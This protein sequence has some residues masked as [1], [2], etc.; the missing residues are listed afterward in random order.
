MHIIEA[1][2]THTTCLPVFKPAVDHA[3]HSGG[4]KTTYYVVPQ[5]WE[6]AIY[7]N[8]AAA[9]DAINGYSGFI[10]IGRATKDEALRTWA[11][12][13]LHSHPKP[14]PQAIPTFWGIKGIKTV[15]HGRVRVDAIDFA[16]THE[17]L[18]IHLFGS[19]EENEVKDFV[20]IRHV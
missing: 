15:F 10:R 20:G 2:L 12:Y 19:I 14:C 11:A 13:C 4:S 9:D 7:T 3:R 18:T 8:A 1:P 5:G 16:E 17:M 6:P